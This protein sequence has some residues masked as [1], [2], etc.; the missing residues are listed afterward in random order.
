MSLAL[1]RRN[2]LSGSQIAE[3]ESALAAFYKSPP[4]SYYPTANQAAQHYT[5]AEQPFHCD[6]LGHVSP[7]MSVLETGCGTAHLCPPIE[8]RGGTYTGVDHSEQLLADN[9]RRFPQARFFAIGMLPAENFDL[10]ASLYTIEHISDPPAYLESLWRYCRPGGMIGII[11]PEF[12]D[13]AG[14][15]PSIVFGKTPRRLREK[16]LT[17]SLA[18]ACQHVIDWKIRAPRWK[19]QAL[20]D[21][22]GA[23]WIN[24]R[25]RVLQADYVIDAD[26]VYLARQRDLGPG[27]AQGAEGPARAPAIAT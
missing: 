2:E 8:E 1:R 19:R 7:G 12:V 18:D 4:P 21:A 24:L 6:L 9:R 14:F 27:H 26:A 16:V 20:A 23:F 17:L 11:C 25:P 22:P 5:H 13:I 15:A 10:V 3:L